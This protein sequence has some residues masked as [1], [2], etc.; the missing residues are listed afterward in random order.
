M[1][2]S[3]GEHKEIAIGFSAAI[4]LSRASAPTPP[5]IAVNLVIQ[6]GKNLGR[7]F[8][9]VGVGKDYDQLMLGSCRELFVAVNKSAGAR[10]K[11]RGEGFKPLIWLLNIEVCECGFQCE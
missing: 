9:W 6:S 4:I 10:F 3:A 2:P 11:V 8:T 5:E 1:S 7:L